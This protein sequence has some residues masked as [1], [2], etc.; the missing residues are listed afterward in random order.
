[1][2]RAADLFVRRI[3]R[4]SDILFFSSRSDDLC[5][6]D[7]RVGYTTHRDSMNIFFAWLLLEAEYSKVHIMRQAV[8]VTRLAYAEL[9]RACTL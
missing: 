2:R 1:M 7:E 4:N 6:W 5:M 3:Q 9:L 8:Y